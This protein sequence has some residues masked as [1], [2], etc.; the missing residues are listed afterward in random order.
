M[1]LIPGVGRSPGKGNSNPLQYSC[2]ENS[3][4]GRAWQTTVY[5]VTKSDMIDQLNNNSSKN[6]GH[7][8]DINR[9]FFKTKANDFES[10]SLALDESTDITDNTIIW[11]I[12]SNFLKKLLFCI[13]VQ[14]INNAVLISG[15]QKSNSVVHIHVAVLFQTL[16]P[17]S[18]LQ[19]T[20]QS[21]LCYTVGS[22]CL[23]ILNIAVCTCQSQMLKQVCSDGRISL[24]IVGMEQLQVRIFSETLR[25]H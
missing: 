15:V 12:N 14:L 10:F 21:S 8:G 23:S 4:D 16:F 6:W 9:T 20:E 7:R 5:G 19:N 11:G 2:L 13:G 17:C 3:M 1:S 18:L 25:K 24:W 22:C